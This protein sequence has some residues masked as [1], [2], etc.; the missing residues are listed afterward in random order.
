VEEMHNRLSSGADP[1]SRPPLLDS[2]QWENVNHVPFERQQVAD[3]DKGLVERP[4]HADSV[5]YLAHLAVRSF[6]PIRMRLAQSVSG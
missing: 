4:S 1:A 5:Q 3:Y 2:A 6:Y